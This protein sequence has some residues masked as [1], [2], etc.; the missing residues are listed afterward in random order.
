M[1]LATALGFA[2]VWARRR[3]VLVSVTGASMEPTLIDGDRILV[4]RRGVGELVR[5]DIAV[6]A[7]P[8]AAQ[9]DP[10]SLICPGWHLKRV[11][12]LPGD[13]MPTGVPGSDGTGLV[14]LGGVVAFGDNLK[15]SDSR[16]WGP[17]PAEGVLGTFVCRVWRIRT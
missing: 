17:Y 12:A 9:S 4:R 16:H 10:V 2:L 15:G 8:A 11:A 3:L 7:A 14:P 5:G 6:L 13:P 1:S